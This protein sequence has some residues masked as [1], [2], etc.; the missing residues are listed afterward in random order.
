VRLGGDGLIAR[1]IEPALFGHA[2]CGW[3]TQADGFD[4]LRGPTFDAGVALDVKV[5]RRFGLGLQ[6][7]FNVV[8]GAAPRDAPYL[9][10]PA[11]VRWLSYGV[12]GEARF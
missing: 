5:T 9:G 12:H 8:V 3:I 6:S 7:A 4:L 2:G 10:G 11:T 1:V